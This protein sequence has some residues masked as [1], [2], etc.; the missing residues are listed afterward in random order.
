MKNKISL[1]T[2]V[3]LSIN[4][5]IGGGIFINTKP[6]TIIGGPLGFVGYL[7]SACLIFPLIVSIAE[8]ARLHPVSGGLYVYSKEYLGA[9]VGF[10]SSWSYFL[11]KSISA[12][13]LIHTVVSFFHQHIT[14]LQTLSV[15]TLDYCLI[16]SL[17]TL[18]VLGVNVAGKAQYLFALLKIIPILFVFIA[19]FVAFDPFI[20]FSSPINLASIPSLI[21]IAL[22]ALI[23]FEVICAI[24]G[25]M[26][27]PEENIRKTILI[28]FFAVLSLIVLFQAG[29][30][31][32]LGNALKNSSEPIRLLAEK[33]FPGFN[34]LGRCMNAIVFT[35]ILGGAFSML[36]SNCWNLY[37]VA[38]NNHL[39]FS[40]LFTR[41]SKTDVPW[42]CIY[43]QGLIASF[44]ITVTH[45]QVAL[46]TMSVF[47]LF[48][49]YF[50]SALAAYQATKTEQRMHLSQWIPLGALLTST[51]V[52]YLCFKNIIIFGVS[53]PFLSI[54]LLGCFAS[55]IKKANTSH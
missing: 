7:V 35:S 10:V 8:L 13:L 27:N 40:S 46:Q 9:Q 17:I 6:L 31:A 51:F 44:I 11:S 53:L 22:Y 52:L 47:A 36:A 34:F 24:G 54:F 50:L 38:K 32:V 2:A 45:T 21:P 20:I 4:T 39:P 41:L 33:A 1:K 30:F 14:F 28:A 18:N 23:G 16:F 19:S 3:L 48:T 42:V 37:T 43:F 25:F 29:L 12:S 5:M 15:L 49:S 55:F 26:E